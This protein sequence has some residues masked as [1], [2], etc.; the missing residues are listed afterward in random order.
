TSFSVVVGKDLLFD[1]SGKGNDPAQ[2]GGTVGYLVERADPV[3]WMCPDKEITLEKAKFGTNYLIEGGMILP[4]GIGSI[5]SKKIIGKTG[6]SITE[7]EPS[8]EKNKTL[9]V[10]KRKYE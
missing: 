9:F 6:G 1:L 7:T 8:T 4:G 2:K 3:C 10:G 5:H